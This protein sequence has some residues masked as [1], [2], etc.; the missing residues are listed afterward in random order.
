MTAQ[1]AVQ[2]TR[3]YLGQFRGFS[4]PIDLFLMAVFLGTL[5]QQI[6][7]LYLNF[8]LLALGRDAA[9]IGLFN[10][11]PN[12]LTLLVGLPVGAISDRIGPR[13]ALIVGTLIQLAA[14]TGLILSSDPWLLLGWVALQ[15][16]GTAFTWA[17]GG[18][19]MMIHS[20]PEQRNAVFSLQQALGNFTGFLGN[21][22]AGYVPL[23]IV[24]LVGGSADS[25]PA[26]RGTLW[27]AAAVLGLSLLP[28]LPIPET[29]REAPAAP[30]GPAGG[31]RPL[32]PRLFTNPG[33][34]LRL[35][36]PGT[37]IG[38]GA[39][40]TMPVL[41][42]FIKGRFGV[43]YGELGLVFALAAVGT[44]V[45]TLLQPLLADHV[46]RVRSTVI[47]QVLSLPFLMIMGFLPIF[48]L[49]VLALV[50]RGA[51]MNMGNPIFT[52]F[53]MEQ[54]PV[55]E[56][57]RFSSLSTMLWSGGWAVGSAFSGWW[58]GLVGFDTGFNTAFALMAGFYVSSFVL[59][60][61]WF[62]RPEAAARRAARALPGASG[63]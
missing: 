21:L 16:V 42:L 35:L 43:D 3:R 37:L 27:L 39:G 5:S 45:A 61:W 13:R 17:N 60:W 46:G 47:V 11:V 41:N 55:A 62:D 18:P 9:F 23:G 8:Y 34:V 6:A 33:L 59:L 24:L 54:I 25:L 14:V 38:F 32:R 4:R 48:P 1:S 26:L 44:M 22:L 50:V 28:L 30:V 20:R 12:V 51:L 15:G 19:F 31:A 52:A 57:A 56:R 58:R 40:M 49:V 7:L 10:A 63:I 53:S 36:L 29:K 2:G